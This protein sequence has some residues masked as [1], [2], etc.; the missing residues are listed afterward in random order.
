MAHGGKTIV[1]KLD[2]TYHKL[3][4]VW[5]G[6]DGSY[7]VTS[8]YHSA[9]EQAAIFVATVDYTLNAQHIGFEELVDSA[10][11]DDD[12]MTLKLAHHKSGFIQF[13]GKGVTSGCND[14]GTPKGVGVFSWS[15]SE[16]VRGPCFGISMCGV[17][18][19]RTVVTKKDT[20]IVFDNRE[21]IHTTGADGFVAEA[22]FFPIAMKRL[23]HLNAQNS[24]VI[25]NVHPN[26]VAFDLRV[27]FPEAG[28]SEIGFLGL[29]IHREHVDVGGPN[30]FM[31][32]SSTGKMRS[33]ANGHTIADAIFAV[34]P[35][36]DTMA[37]RRNLAWPPLSQQ[38]IASAQ[39]DK[40]F[41]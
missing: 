39:F 41:R 24:W 25:S 21:I 13:S 18:S 31:M 22:Y 34:F 32:S 40:R 10:A 29:E 30:G 9:G 17:G 37:L 16:P 3:F 33:D 14:D 1:L 6:A 36:S 20:D 27:I 15:L 5:F 7:Y 19:Y 11:L 28:T 4:K 38:A 35:R 26:G 8:P 23:V 12:D 2:G